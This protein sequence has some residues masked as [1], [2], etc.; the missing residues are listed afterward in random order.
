LVPNP[1]KPY[2]RFALTKEC[3]RKSAREARSLSYFF[4]GAL[5]V[6]AFVIF[7]VFRKLDGIRRREIPVAK[8]V[9]MY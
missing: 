2:M 5:S 6:G 4:V 8:G 7:A 1:E 9:P 3:C